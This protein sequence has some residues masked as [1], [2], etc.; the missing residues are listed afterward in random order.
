MACQNPKGRLSFRGSLVSWPAVRWACCWCWR[1]DRS[2]VPRV[3]SCFLREPPTRPTRKRLLP[4]IEQ[5]FEATS[6]SAKGLCDSAGFVQKCRRA[7]IDASQRLLTLFGRC[8]THFRDVIS[9]RRPHQEVSSIVVPEHFILTV[10]QHRR[11][12]RESISDPMTELPERGLFTG[13]RTL[14]LDPRCHDRDYAKQCHG[15]P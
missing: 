5:R 9:D 3:H 1:R 8:D 14:E 11:T 13:Q 12:G 7:R 10:A 15:E 2:N 6:A 4:E